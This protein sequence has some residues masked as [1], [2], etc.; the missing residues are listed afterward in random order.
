MKRPPPTYI[1]PDFPRFY[2]LHGGLRFAAAHLKKSMHPNM[3]QNTFRILAAATY[4][5]A[6]PRKLF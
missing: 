6:P 3:L 1:V 2:F 5:S 4:V